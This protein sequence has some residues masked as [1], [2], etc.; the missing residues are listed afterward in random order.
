MPDA[1]S[2]AAAPQGWPVSLS[3]TVIRVISPGGGGRPWRGLVQPGGGHAVCLRMDAAPPGLRAGDDVHVR[4]AERFASGDGLFPDE[5]IARPAGGGARPAPVTS[6]PPSPAVSARELAGQLGLAALA[7]AAAEGLVRLA[8]APGVL[9]V[10]RSRESSDPAIAWAMD[11]F[12]DPDTDAMRGAVSMILE[13]AALVPRSAPA[14]GFGMASRAA[15]AFRSLRG[16]PGQKPGGVWLAAAMPALQPDAE[17]GLSA[18][19]AME[20]DPV[21]REATLGLSGSWLRMPDIIVPHNPAMTGCEFWRKL[22][23]APAG[24]EPREVVPPGGRA[25]IAVGHEMAHAYQGAYG[26]T[27]GTDAQRNAAEC[28]AD[29]AAVLCCALDAGDVPSARAFGR[30]R[31]LSALMGTVT[32]ATG[33]TCERAIAEAERL[34]A[35]HGPGRVPLARILDAAHRVAQASAHPDPGD[36]KRFRAA[37]LERHPDFDRMPPRLMAHAAT[38]ALAAQAGGPAR[39]DATAAFVLAALEALPRTALT[40]HDMLRAANVMAARK[41]ERDDL[42]G[43]AASLRAAGLGGLV[44]AVVHSA[45]ARASAEW[46]SGNELAMERAR[47]VLARLVPGMAQ[48]LATP[49]EGQRSLRHGVLRA[50]AAAAQAAIAAAIYGSCIR[51]AADMERIADVHRAALGHIAR[52]GRR[53]TARRDLISVL[54]GA[55]APAGRTAF[56]MPVTERMRRLGEMAWQELQLLERADGADGAGLKVAAA[57]LRGLRDRARP[58]AWSIRVE[59]REWARLCRDWT[60]IDLESVRRLALDRPTTAATVAT[61]AAGLARARADFSRFRRMAQQTATA[62]DLRLHRLFLDG[63]PG[64]KPLDWSGRDLRW[65]DLGRI[66][67]IS[68]RGADLSR[69]DLRGCGASSLDLSGARL[70]GAL[71]DVR[72]PAATPAAS[73]GRTRTGAAAGVRKLH[74]EDGF[75]MTA[76]DGTGLAFVDGAPAVVVEF[77]GSGGERRATRLVPARG[78]RLLAAR[79]AYGPDAS[80]VTPSER[81]FAAI[82]RADG[83]GDGAPTVALGAAAA[84][85]P[86]P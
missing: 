72:P 14:R 26:Y 1:I 73:P 25:R 64:G 80:I 5:V 27:G 6:C 60:E 19:D 77:T 41:V 11:R 86:A 42:S 58:V 33:L 20:A 13:P 45:S 54:P 23:R 62:E 29:A 46:A 40:P 81:H 68:L 65:M 79:A 10:M 16:A 15:E 49:R 85:A 69:A 55:D 2:G 4:G 53:V 17:R 3:G 48:A 36:L 18:S 70:D 34:R 22:T 67:G 32:H 21:R 74:C 30:M 47:R 51:T 39:P 38:K 83:A 59:A 78:A 43:T 37:L 56:D 8:A 7:G 57:S 63:G 35:A 31:A 76:P 50:A 84:S 44:P 24:Y 52:G 9:A 28:F 75:A 71:L 82:R 12:S 61:E 66:K